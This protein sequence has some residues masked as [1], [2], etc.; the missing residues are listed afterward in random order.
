MGWDIAITQNGP[1]TIEGNHNTNIT[2]SEVGYGGY[3]K[4]P[5]VK[6]MLRATV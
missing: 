6:E 2:M 4:H 3:K 1:I 5:L